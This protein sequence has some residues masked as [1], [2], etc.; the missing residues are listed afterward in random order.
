MTDDVYKGWT[1]PGPRPPGGLEPEEGETLDFITGHY[2]LFQ[3]KRG[4]RFSTDDILTAWYGTTWCPRPA[5]VADLGSGIGSVATCVAWRCPGA[6]IHTVEA[7]AISA[8]LARKSVAYN[9]LQDRY[10]I[11]EGDLRDPDLFPDEAP[12]DLVTGSPPYWPVGSKAEAAH[13]QAIPAR[14]EVRGDIG[15]Y[16]RAAARIL[17]PGGIFACVFP[18]DQVERAA[19]AYRDADLL[20]M[21]RQDVVFKEGEPYGIALFA[22]CRKGDLP[23]GFGEAAA[24]PR[25][26]PPLTIRRRDGSV[27]PSIAMVR[28]AMGFPPGLALG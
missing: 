8:R 12:F 13:P 21:H 24:F 23:E 18:S 27:D 19:R 16:A 20:L 17:A 9:G 15:D 4:H 22:G 1:R 7:Q 25:V 10:T 26:A 6:R 14:L 3:Y 28:L 5:R 11:H 2:R